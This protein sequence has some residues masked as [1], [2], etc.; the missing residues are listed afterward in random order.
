MVPGNRDG[1][2]RV[3]ILALKGGA[4]RPR[5][6]Y[7]PRKR[8]L[9][10]NF[11]KKQGDPGDGQDW[12]HTRKFSLQSGIKSNSSSPQ[13]LGTS[14]VSNQ[15]VA[16]Y[17]CQCMR[18]Q[19]K[20]ITRSVSVISLHN[21]TLSLIVRRSR[22]GTVWFYTS[23]SNKRAARPKLYTQSLTRDLKLMYNRLT[24][25]RISIKL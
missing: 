8:N 16:L 9:D 18:S 24:L 19:E 14:V 23:T 17:F 10:T 7:Q 21:Y 25:V 22:M 15:E 5:Q 4:Q 20:D 2:H 6:L 12:V 11:S 1:A 3:F 13:S